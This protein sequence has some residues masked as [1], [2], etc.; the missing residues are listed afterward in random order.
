MIKMTNVCPYCGEEWWEKHECHG[1][2]ALAAAEAAAE[3]EEQRLRSLQAIDKLLASQ[4][5]GDVL[6]GD[7]SGYTFAEDVAGC[8][9]DWDNNQSWGDNPDKDHD[10]VDHPKHYTSHPSGVECIDITKH[11]NF[12][13][14][15][16]MKYLWRQGLKDEKGLDPVEKQIQDCKKAIWYIN[17]FIEDLEGK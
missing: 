11:Y 5:W 12:Q 8:Q 14:G 17:N 10:A 13:I 2:R 3:A 9:A 7:L 16:A 4:D 6:F 15:S 1:T